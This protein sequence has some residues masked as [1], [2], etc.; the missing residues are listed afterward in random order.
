MTML[1]QHRSTSETSA[2]LDREAAPRLAARARAQCRCGGVGPISLQALCAVTGVEVKEAPL[3]AGAGG[4][5]ALLVPCSEDRFRIVLDQSFA[6][7]S[8]A[9]CSPTVRHRRRFR[10]AHELGH[11]HAYSRGSGKPRRL[12]PPGSADEEVFCDE[13]ARHLLVPSPQDAAS[14]PAVVANMHACD[15]SLEVSARATASIHPAPRV[16]LWWW[17]KGTES[18]VLE[19]WASDPALSEELGLVRYRTRP[20]SLPSLVETAR[21]RLGKGLSVALLSQRRQALVVLA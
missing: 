19:Q 16:A 8:G 2:R 18:V 1:Q 7:E 10:I 4:P 13:F 14:A 15:V 17:R 20:A 6:L 11:I 9:T 3:G 12:F 21:K 5:E